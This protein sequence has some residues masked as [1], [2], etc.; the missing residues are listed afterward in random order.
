MATQGLRLAVY[1]AI[2][3]AFPQRQTGVS[4]P[5]LAALCTTLHYRD[6]SAS[7]VAH[8]GPVEV[9]RLPVGRRPDD[10]TAESP[11]GWTMSG[12]PSFCEA[13]VTRC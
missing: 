2:S 11:T 4:T 12:E 8:Y 7:L 10:E 3:Y 5:P 13:K 9:L 1:Y 6:C